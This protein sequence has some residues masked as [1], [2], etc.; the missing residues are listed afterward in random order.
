MTDQIKQLESAA[1][2]HMFTTMSA[3]TIVATALLGG[4]LSLSGL[5]TVGVLATFV[6]YIMNLSSPNAASTSIST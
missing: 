4:W 6:V 1:L 5:V 2:V 3:I